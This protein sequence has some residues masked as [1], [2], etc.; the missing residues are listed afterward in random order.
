VPSD[1]AT[2]LRRPDDAEQM[3]ELA[4]LNLRITCTFCLAARLDAARVR[5]CGTRTRVN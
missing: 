5:A 4:R 3:H 1:R 2:T